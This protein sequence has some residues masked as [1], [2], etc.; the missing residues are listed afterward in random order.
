M[1][2][3]KYLLIIIASCVLICSNAHALDK[4]QINVGILVPINSLYP[5][6][7][8]ILEPMYVMENIFETL[9]KMKEGSIEI[10]PCLA[11]RID[12]SPDYKIWTAY[13]R[14][15]VTFHDDTPFNAAA[16]VASFSVPDSLKN[17]VKKLDDY[18]VVFTLD[19]PNVTFPITL[20]TPYY[21]IASQST[22]DCY[23]TNCRTP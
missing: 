9:T 13:L 19:K 20:S 10:E 8:I 5:W 15:N 4:E 18:T 7:E 11:L 17:K 14:K 2:Y 16:V 21:G 12:P 23:K 22:I 1:L 3:K 6:G